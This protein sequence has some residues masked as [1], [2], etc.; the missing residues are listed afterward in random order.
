[1]CIRY[2][3]ELMMTG[4]EQMNL[5]VKCMSR[6]ATVM[7]KHMRLGSLSLIGTVPILMSTYCEEHSH[8][9]PSLYHLHLKHWTIPNSLTL[10]S[11]FKILPKLGFEP[12][13]S[14]TGSN[15]S[16]N[17]AETNVPKGYNPVVDLC[18]VKVLLIWA[19]VVA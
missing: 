16:A 8:V 15:R 3:V 12:R 7:L 4:F 14:G 19:V 1:M 18:V 2:T 17:S 11:C 13:M 6:C 9:I 5:G 10:F